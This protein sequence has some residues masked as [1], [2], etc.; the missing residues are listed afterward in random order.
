VRPGRRTSFHFS[1]VEI[2][3]FMSTDLTTSGADRD[4]IR[5]WLGELRRAGDEFEEFVGEHLDDL[6]TLRVRIDERQRDLDAQH[7]ELRRQLA[8]LQ[9]SQQRLDEANVTAERC[10]G[11]LRDLA[12]R[13]G[14]EAGREV[15][16]QVAELRLD[17]ERFRE[18]F[19]ASQ[20]Q[21]QSLAQTLTAELAQARAELVAA[22]ADLVRERQR[23]TD[24]EAPLHEALATQIALLEERREALAAPPTIAEL[25]AE[26]A[27]ESVPAGASADGEDRHTW[28]SELDR[29]RSGLT[30]TPRAT[31]K[32]PSTPASPTVD[33]TT[34]ES[35]RGDAAVD[36]PVLDSVMAQFE[37][38]QNDLAGR[39]AT[40]RAA[41][42]STRS[43]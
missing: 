17:R 16:D 38:L 29:L 35:A 42:P 12:E 20:S 9:E 33:P 25:P 8:A 24:A 6:E 19:E 39:R 11:Q 26:P 30:K 37:M 14:S 23:L 22:S 34:A 3:V 13:F 4:Q 21:A 1:L 36:D 43:P 40:P 5:R 32:Q 27:Q 10:A 28:S 41:R 15:T 2:V 18:Q 7:D 31:T